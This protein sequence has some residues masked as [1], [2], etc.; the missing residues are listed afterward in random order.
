[1]PG[2]KRDRHRPSQTQAHG[3]ARPRSFPGWTR[4]PYTALPAVTVYQTVHS[5]PG[6]LPCPAKGLYFF[7]VFM[8][9]SMLS[10]FLSAPARAGLLPRIPS[11]QGPPFSDGPFFIPYG[12]E[13]G[14]ACAAPFFPQT[15]PLGRHRLSRLLFL[16]GL[17]DP[18]LQGVHDLAG[19]IGAGNGELALLPVFAAHFLVAADHILV[20]AV[21]RGLRLPFLIA[22]EDSGPGAL[23]QDDLVQFLED[24]LS[25]LLIF[26]CEIIDGFAQNCLP[27]ERAPGTCTVEVKSLHGP[28]GPCHPSHGAQSTHFGAKRQACPPWAGMAAARTGACGFPGSAQYGTLPPAV[29]PQTDGRA[30]LSPQKV[31]KG[32]TCRNGPAPHQENHRRRTSLPAQGRRSSDRAKRSTGAKSSRRGSVTGR[33][34][35]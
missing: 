28:P 11:H 1:M 13:K 19:L 17:P 9:G 7:H 34:G 23:A 22:E 33:E 8:T 20:G 2:K 29:F 35:R 18:G 6:A 26:H 25:V 32:T 3:K 14:A 21:G 4:C 12:H 24:D 27:C 30:A 16:L 15:A 31:T 10:G 5:G